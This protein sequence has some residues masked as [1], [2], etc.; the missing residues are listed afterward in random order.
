MSWFMLP[1]RRI[2]LRLNILHERPITVEAAHAP[3]S[4]PSFGVKRH[5]AEQARAHRCRSHRQRQQMRGAITA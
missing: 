5:N 1:I 4:V 2:E 3:S